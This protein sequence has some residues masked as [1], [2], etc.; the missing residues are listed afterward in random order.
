MS[1]G[2]LFICSFSKIQQGKGFGSSVV[3]TECTGS[4]GGLPGVTVRV[5]I[6]LALFKQQVTVSSSVKNEL[7]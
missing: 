1:F 2:I 5:T 4:G 6:L 7:Q 3:V